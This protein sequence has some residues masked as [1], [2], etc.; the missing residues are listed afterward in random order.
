MSESK[1]L[2]IQLSSEE[3][4]HLE[5]EAKRL[6]LPPDALAVILFQFSLAQAK[7]NLSIDSLAALWRLHE[8]T[9]DLPGVDPVELIHAGQE[10][11]EER[12]IF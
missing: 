11:L 3:R 12:G 4:A 8:L 2:T 5:A 7:T 6:H 10:N 9:K 1:T